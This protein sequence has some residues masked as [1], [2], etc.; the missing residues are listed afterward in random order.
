MR[1]SKLLV[2]A[3]VVLS[4]ISWAGFGALASETAETPEQNAAVV[5]RILASYPQLSLKTEDLLK[6]LE[7]GYGLGDLV[8]ASELASRA[9]ITFAEII[10][11]RQEGT[12]W[13][14][15]A[16]KL[17]LDERSFGQAVNGI[18]GNGEGKQASAKEDKEPKAPKESRSKQGKEK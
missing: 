6:L 9:N 5:A 13:G 14:A 3:I 16:K 1:K 12:G 15:M 17:G 7:E 8:I 10:A 2:L 11:M 18:V 4:V